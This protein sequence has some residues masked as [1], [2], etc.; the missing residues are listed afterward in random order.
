MPIGQ[1][2]D[3]WG[4]LPAGG[5]RHIQ[6]A[7]QVQ[8]NRQRQHQVIELPPGDRLPLTG[9]ASFARR[10]GLRSHE[11]ETIATGQVGQ[12][13]LMPAV[14]TRATGPNSAIANS[15]LRAHAAASAIRMVSPRT[16]AGASVQV[17]DS[18]HEDGMKLIDGTPEAIMALRAAQPGLRV[19]PVVFY[20]PAL[21]ARPTLAV[22]PRALAAAAGTKLTVRVVSAKD[23]SPVAGADV[24]A[25][26]NFA[27]RAG[28]EGTTK[29][30]G[31]VALALGGSSKKLERLYV[32]P[33]AG[34]WSLLSKRVT[35]SNGSTLSLKPLDV[36]LVDGVRFFAGASTLQD[37]DGVTVGV[38]DTGVDTGHPDL[39]LSGGFNVIKGEDPGDFGDNGEHHGT[40]VAGI[41][42][43]RGSAPKGRLGIAP[44]VSLRSYRVF[45][46]RGGKSP[47]GTN[48]D[49]AK[50]IDRAVADGCDLINISLEMLTDAENPATPDSVIRDAIAAARSAGVLVIVAAGNQDRGPVSFPAADERSVAVSALGR[51]GT[52]PTGTSESGDVAGPFG[53]DK[54]NF[55]AAFS[56]IGRAIDLTGPGVGIISTVPGG[57]GVESGTSMACPAVT[58]FAA[59]ILGRLPDIRKQARNQERSD[60]IAQAL[61]ASVR[62]L[63]FK[64]EFE[65]HGLPS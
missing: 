59:R 24:L 30:N 57:Y 33:E 32:Y 3:G 47:G 9:L 22:A 51:K 31:E 64:P 18:I 43:A 54:K 61:F 34:F 20:R 56:N 49:V 38:V 41:I 44:G 8:P 39:R 52:F 11:E 53:K 45:G 35:V 65:G 29:K 1:A 4:S 46:K 17:V 2:G 10:L 62:D 48:F 15:F 21:A 50:A 60:A 16:P 12:Y 58:G 14:G 25:Y 36:T 23:G 27:A 40:H 37:G 13:V 42:A 6:A 26:T 5:V 55:I 63:G 7:G 19:V 28:V